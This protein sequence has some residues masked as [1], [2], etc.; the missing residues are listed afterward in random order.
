MKFHSAT[1]FETDHDPYC[2]FG[3]ISAPLAGLLAGGLTD[4]GVGAGTA[5][6]LGGIGAGALTGA[7][8]GAL[9]G[10]ITGSN[11][12]TGALTGGLT[13]GAVG[14]F[15]P[16]VG[17]ALGI[18]TTG[19]DILTGAVAGG[20]GS[21]LT[22]QNPLTGALTG[23]AGGALAG[24]TGGTSTGGSTV[25]PTSAI[26]PGAA[27]GGG[28]ASAASTAGISPSGVG[29]GATGGTGVDLTSTLGLTPLS[30]P[31][32]TFTGTIDPTSVNPL[33]SIS[34]NTNAAGAGASGAGG[35]NNPLGGIGSFISKNPGLALGV[36]ALGA[37]LLFGNQ[38]LPAE[39][40]IQNLA[41]QAQSQASTLA[42]YQ[43]SGTLPPGL[44]SIVDQQVDAAKA[45]LT[46]TYGNLGL[47][48]STM[49]ADK[50]NQLKATRSAE[51]AQFADNLAKQGVQWEQLSS[52]ELGQLLQAQEFGQ[53]QFTQALSSFA[54]GL[55]GGGFGSST[56]SNTSSATATAA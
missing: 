55:A 23:G 9:L 2:H 37:D 24:L 18:G 48:N 29:G 27:T 15:G 40:Q 3:L 54:R 28:A 47:G 14:G 31:S 35:T 41:G 22:G 43:Q 5:A 21:L 36:G 39:N 45:Q 32:S 50:L 19:G 42:A 8:G 13:G 49:L 16:S 44:Q 38:P 11:P 20:A 46:T 7:G 56:G 33:G 17:S 26:S 1:L 34:A 30:A 12:L 4:I 51:I 10:E 52:Q 25:A 53:Q 6:T